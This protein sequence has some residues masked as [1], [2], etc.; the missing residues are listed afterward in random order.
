MNLTSTEF[1]LEFEPGEYYFTITYVPWDMFNPY[2]ISIE[3]K[4]QGQIWAPR[5]SP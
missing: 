4:K 3:V 1:E 2:N 5:P